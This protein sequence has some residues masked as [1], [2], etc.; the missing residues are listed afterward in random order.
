MYQSQHPSVLMFGLDALASKV[1]IRKPNSC[2]NIEYHSEKLPVSSNK[3]REL[4]DDAYYE[5]LTN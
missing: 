5:E 4:I 2:C 3:N 1:S